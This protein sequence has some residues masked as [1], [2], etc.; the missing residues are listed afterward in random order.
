M[1]SAEFWAK[2]EDIVSRARAKTGSFGEDAYDTLTDFLL[3]MDA[4]A[5]EWYNRGDDDA[6]EK[7]IT[8][9]RGKYH[10]LSNFHLVEIELDGE[11]YPTLEHAYQAA[12]STDPVV[13]AAINAMVT[14][15]L[16]RSAGCS[17]LIGDTFRPDWDQA[18]IGIMHAL[19]RKKFAHPELAEQLLAT[20]DAHLEEGNNHGDTFWGTVSGEGENN[21][22]VLLMV[23][24]A[25][26]QAK[27]QKAPAEPTL[28][29]FE[30]VAKELGYY[31]HSYGVDRESAVYMK[32]GVTLTVELTER[33][34]LRGR[35]DF[36]WKLLTVS[37]GRFSLPHPK[38][39]VF[40][41]QVLTAKVALERESSMGVPF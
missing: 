14:P 39:N 8:S 13:R 29:P 7:A 31:L 6:G 2:A 35:I 23:V 18:R 41:G 4:L 24:R 9:F 30:K 25:E 28:L 12:K 32:N 1:N 20:G 11:I 5:S 36:V 16:A 21:L 10:F 15:G 40:E 22:G 34:E 26:L 37:T 38:F 3:D 27:G 33:G 19:L 17:K